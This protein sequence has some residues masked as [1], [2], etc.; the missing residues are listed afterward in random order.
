MEININRYKYSV[1]RL[2]KRLQELKEKS[3]DAILSFDKDDE[4]AMDFVTA[5]ANLRAYIFHIPQKSRFEVKCKLI[6]EIEKI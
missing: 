5:T 2:S 4:D 1:E 6:P 3:N